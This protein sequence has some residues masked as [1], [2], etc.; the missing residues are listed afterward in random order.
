MHFHHTAEGVPFRHALL[1]HAIIK[2]QATYLSQLTHPGLLYPLPMK[3]LYHALLLIARVMP[4]QTSEQGFDS[5]C[6]HGGCCIQESNGLTARGLCL[7]TALQLCNNQV[8][9]S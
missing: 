6:V 8:V 7:A 3:V 4:V 1:H 5:R 9:Q 2:Q